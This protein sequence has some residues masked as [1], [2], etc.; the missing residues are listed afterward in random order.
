MTAKLSNRKRRVVVTGIGAV[1]PLGG[2][3]GETWNGIVEGMVV[4]GPVQRFDASQFPTKIAYEVRDF[5]FRDELVTA[6]E[7]GFL[8]LAAQYGL[9]AA[10]EAAIEAGLFTAAAKQAIDPRRVAVCLGVGMCSPDFPWYEDVLIPQNW[11]HPALAQHIRYF[12]DQLTSVAA[13]ILGAKG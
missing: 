8:S 6:R 5:R 12:P 13:R 4:A 2:T 3:F 1:T 7:K 9:N 11:Q 10:H